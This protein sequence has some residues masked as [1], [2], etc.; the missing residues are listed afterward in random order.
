ML[1]RQRK[2]LIQ[3]NQSLTTSI[4]LSPTIV[5]TNAEVSFHVLCLL[6][7]ISVADG[8]EL[9]SLFQNNMKTLY[10]STEIWN[11]ED[12]RKYLLT[13]DSYFIIL[14]INTEIIGFAMFK[15]EWDDLDDP[16]VP[17]VYL[18]E[19]QIQESS[20]GKQLGIQAIQLIERLVL[21]HTTVIKKMVRLYL[22]LFY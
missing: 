6:K 12:K 17:V 1:S 8:N 16:S 14:R 7:N 19:L 2:A 5:Y 13:E 21:Q 4:S 22:P 18:Y 15:L 20:R 10:E 3:A 9:F 11:S